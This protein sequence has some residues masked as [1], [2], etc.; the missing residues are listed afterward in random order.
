[1]CCHFLFFQ[2]KLTVGY[3]KQ[4]QNLWLHIRLEYQIFTKNHLFFHPTRNLTTVTINE[5][6]WASL[7]KIFLALYLY[8]S[9][10]LES[11]L[12]DSA[13]KLM[14]DVLNRNVHQA[15]RTFQGFW[16]YSYCL[17]RI[18]IHRNIRMR[19]E[20]EYY[21]KICC[22]LTSLSKLTKIRKR[23]SK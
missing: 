10:L 18:K 11:D 12:F 9:G 6:K 1:M 19:G 22:S 14:A 13:T 16:T 5:S 17:Q 23:V 8:I 20:V 4:S 21:I 2:T 15:L 3:C 7:F